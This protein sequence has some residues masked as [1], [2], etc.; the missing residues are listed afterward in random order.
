MAGRRV[1]IAIAGGGLAGGLIALAL[2]R[3]RPELSVVL[4]EAGDVLGGNHRWSW[5][6]SD[7]PPADADVLAPFRKTRWSGYDVV[8]PAHG[9]TLRS[10]YNSLASEDFDAGLRRELAQDTILPRRSVDALDAGG[11]DLSDGSRI[12]ARAVIDVRGFVPSPHLQGG[13][14][15]FMGRHVR[16]A[17]PHGV[18][19]PIVMDADVVQHGAYRFVYTLPLGANE[20]FVEE[21]YYAD[22]PRLDRRALSA[23]IDAYCNQRGWRGDILGGE[24]GVLPVVTGG[25]LSQ[26]LAAQRVPG[27]AMAGARGMLAHPLTSY[28]LPFA[29]ETAQL[30]ARNADLPGDQLAALLEAQSR[31]VW[32]RT[33]FYRTLGQMLF[34]AA[35]PDRRYRIFE[36]FYRL[37]EPL[38]E[39]FY[40]GRSTFADRLRILSGRP[41]VPVTRAVGALLSSR[42]ALQSGGKAH[43]PER[44]VSP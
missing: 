24:T 1:D 15:V 34:G 4:V 18:D 33:K 26:H 6:D 9:R 40:A 22:G 21:T 39:R 8:F 38:V 3:A 25:D 44:T 31:R 20:L 36:R 30:V 32:K 12:D 10:R 13:W 37:P 2:R 11:V 17:K 29:V 14:Q 16:T 41:P 23:R 19:R 42:P 35:K 27:V 43:Q 5:F 7:I 28:T